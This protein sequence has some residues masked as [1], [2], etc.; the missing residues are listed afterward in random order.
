[1]RLCIL[2]IL[3]FPLITAIAAVLRVC[4]V[5]I[6]NEWLVCILIGQ[7]GPWKRLPLDER[8]DEP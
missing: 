4:E 2:A 1:M 6:S 8:G 3:G 5:S 7:C